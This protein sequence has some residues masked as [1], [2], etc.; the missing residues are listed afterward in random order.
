MPKGGKWSYLVGASI[1][2]GIGFTMSLFVTG[3][4][5]DDPSHIADAKVGILLGS[6]IAAGVGVTVLHRVLPLTS[7][8][9]RA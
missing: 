1:L 7:S 5:F 2:G 9:D 3:L 6:V 4:A 8:P